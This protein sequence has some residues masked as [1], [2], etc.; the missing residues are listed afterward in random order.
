ML[1]LGIIAFT[2]PPALAGNAVSPN[3]GAGTVSIFCGNILEENVTGV[4]FNLDADPGFYIA[5]ANLG[6]LF[7][8]VDQYRA[9]E[10]RPFENAINGDVIRNSVS[11]EAVINGTAFGTIFRED[12]IGV[13]QYGIPDLSVS[14]D[15]QLP[16]ADSP[17]DNRPICFDSSDYPWIYYPCSAS[18]ITNETSDTINWGFGIGSD[19]LS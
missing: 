10:L 3:Y 7:D 15:P 1:L 17:P 19:Y 11:R 4:V 18:A 16:T 13:A 9:Y 2:K 8:G 6:V 5:F 14:C 12:F